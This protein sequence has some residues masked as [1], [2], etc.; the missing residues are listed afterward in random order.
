MG[1]LLLVAHP[2]LTGGCVM[3]IPVI[4]Q[5]IASK[6]RHG[7]LPHAPAD[8]LYGGVGSYSTCCCC[9]CTIPPGEYELEVEFAELRISRS[10][11]R[12]MHPQCLRLWYEECR[13]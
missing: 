7:E 10:E 11:T 5:M 12:F 1:N 9:D 6:L 8:N 13:A 3:D 4:R 2:L